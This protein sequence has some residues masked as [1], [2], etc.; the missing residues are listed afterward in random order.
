MYIHIIRIICINITIYLLLCL[1]PLV[2]GLC[3]LFLKNIT[4]AEQIKDG[5]TRSPEQVQI[6]KKPD[7]SYFEQ[8]EFEVMRYLLHH[9][10][11]K[12]RV[13]IV[14]YILYISRIVH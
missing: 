14:I 5:P 8:L 13:E 3:Q 7:F 11:H 6:L 2:S 4:T 1:F 9:M 10:I 12:V